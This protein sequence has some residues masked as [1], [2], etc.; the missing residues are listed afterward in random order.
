MVPTCL[1]RSVFKGILEWWLLQHGPVFCG[2]GLF[3][4]F[5]CWGQGGGKCLATYLEGKVAWVIEHSQ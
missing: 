2:R 3:F 1:Y 5:F 4:F